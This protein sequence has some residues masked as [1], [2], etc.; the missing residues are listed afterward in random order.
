M[1][2]ILKNN[3]WEITYLDSNRVPHTFYHP[4]EI[5]DIDLYIETGE[6]H[7]VQITEQKLKEVFPSDVI[8]EEY[9]KSMDGVMFGDAPLGPI[10][11]NGHPIDP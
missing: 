5:S 1:K 3:Q 4:K 2:Y 7:M 8:T 9:L 6:R 10:D 11:S